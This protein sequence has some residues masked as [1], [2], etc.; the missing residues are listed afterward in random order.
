MIVEQNKSKIYYNGSRWK[1]TKSGEFEIVGKEKDRYIC[2]FDDGYT[3]ISD[4]KEIRNGK[5]LK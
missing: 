1:T 2:R 5:I 4:S 3:I